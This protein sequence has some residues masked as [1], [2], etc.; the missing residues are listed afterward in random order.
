MDYPKALTSS[1]WDKKK[2]LLAKSHATGLSEALEALK[3]QHSSIAWGD[4]N[5]T[6]WLRAHPE[7][8]AFEQEMDTRL[9]EIETKL[10]PLAQQ[11]DKVAQ[12]AEKTA[13]SLGKDRLVPKSATQ[14]AQTVAETATRFGKDLKSWVTQLEKQATALLSK[15][16]PKAGEPDEP[17]DQLLAP[18]LLKTVLIRCRKNEGL[19]AHFAYCPPDQ[20]EATFVAHMRTPGRRLLAKVRTATGQSKGTSGT[21][22]VLDGELQLT[23]EKLFTGLVKQVRAITKNAGV[24]FTAIRLLDDK[25]QAL[26]SDQDDTDPLLSL[27]GELQSLTDAISAALK[28]NPALRAPVLSAVSGVQDGIKRDEV[29][30]AEIAMTQL[31]AL[32]ASAKPKAKSSA[33]T[34]TS[35]AQPEALKQDAGAQAACEARKKFLAPRLKAALSLTAIASDIKER[36]AQAEDLLKAGNAREALERLADLESH[37][38]DLD[39]ARAD[40]ETR[41]TQVLQQVESL[42]IQ[43]SLKNQARLKKVREFMLEKVASGDFALAGK[44]LTELNKLAEAI[45][46]EMTPGTAPDDTDDESTGEF[47]QNMNA[48]TEWL[49]QV[50]LLKETRD[51]TLELKALGEPEHATFAK[52]L[53]EIDKFAKAEQFSKAL[54]VLL[55]LHPRV[56]LRRNQHPARKSW[57]D[58]ADLATQ[59]ASRLEQLQALGAPEVPA[60]RY[61]LTFATTMGNADRYTEATQALNDVHDLSAQLLNAYTNDKDFRRWASMDVDFLKVKGQLEQAEESADDLG[62]DLTKVKALEKAL[63]SIKSAVK[64]KDFAAACSELKAL[65]PKVETYQ[66]TVALLVKHENAIDELERPINAADAITPTGTLKKPYDAYIDAWNAMLKANNEKGASKLDGLRGKMTEKLFA[67]LSAYDNLP[68]KSGQVNAAQIDFERYADKQVRLALKKIQDKRILPVTAAMETMLADVE[69]AKSAMN[70]HSGSQQWVQAMAKAQEVVRLV[71]RLSNAMNDAG[72]DGKAF[73]R[74]HGSL[75]KR[76]TG[77]EAKVAT[78]PKP[79][80][81]AQDA[82]MRAMTRMA[83]LRS[84]NPVD[85]KA[86]SAHLNGQLEPAMNALLVQQAQDTELEIVQADTS[87]KARV[88]INTKKKWELEALPAKQKVDLLR[89]LRNAWADSPDDREAQRAIYNAMSLEPD[90]LAYDKEQRAKI[91]LAL[92]DDPALKQAKTGWQAMDWKARAK[93]LEKVALQQC[94]AFGFEPVPVIKLVDLGGDDNSVTNGYFDPNTKCIVIN[95]NTYSSAND[96]ERA[97]DLIVHENSHYYQDQLCTGM[98]DAARRDKRLEAQTLLFKV[99]DEDYVPPSEDHATYQKQPVEEHAHLAGPKAAKALLA[100]L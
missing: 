91:V 62:L 9:K 54:S 52:L 80:T 39:T 53:D 8:E 27:K 74:K 89:Q 34:S 7:A 68:D 5:P 97:V 90:F 85:Y 75:S 3:K 2:G 15:I 86:C 13:I 26:E 59:V 30:A 78:R 64:N 42:L 20:D 16:P 12:L 19:Q 77:L 84:A 65:V 44:T 38:D 83:S 79:W 23:V 51:K 76:L 17:D 73:S 61:G 6:A 24:R 95:V 10:K 88:L 82:F 50:D 25:G 66:A 29:A 58:V 41:S 22:R 18:D 11:T 21:L 43:I 46:K 81:Q 1:D 67:L 100:A 31:K 28:A 45:R 99:N 96:F 40:Y 71:E 98:I 36:Y 47:L 63:K 35:A 48:Q 92:K 70:T 32:L 94:K 37:L 72:R 69:A 49:Q 4:H 33:D 57:L 56:E 55:R 14:A 87:D 93:L 60:L